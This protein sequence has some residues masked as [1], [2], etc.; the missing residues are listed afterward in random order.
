[1]VGG[2][3]ESAIPGQL[4][5]ADIAYMQEHPDDIYRALKLKQQEMAA[6]EVAAV[7]E[8]AAEPTAI[9]RL[10]ELEQLRRESQAAEEAG[11]QAAEDAK[12]RD[13]RILELQREVNRIRTQ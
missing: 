2:G 4:T 9:D 13:K 1:V 12:T 7:A 8:S 3:A 6:A 10:M 5:E 11:E